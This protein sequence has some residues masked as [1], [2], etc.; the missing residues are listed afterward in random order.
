MAR[1]RSIKPE[2]WTSD[3]VVECSTNAR[4]LFIG[5]WNF[6]DDS[7]R[8]PYSPRRLKMCIFPGD[9]H[10]TTDDVAHLMQ[11]LVASK[12]IVPYEVNGERY[13][14]VSGWSHQKI[15]KR[16]EPKWAGPE[17]GTILET[18]HDDS[19]NDRG[20]VADESGLI[21]K[22]TIG[23]D[24]KGNTPIAPKGA[25]K[26]TPQFEEFWKA[27]PQRVGKERAFKAWGKSIKRIGGDR[28]AAAS[29][30]IGAAIDFAQ[31]TVGRGDYCP[32]PSTW[33]NAGQYDDDR[34]AWNRQSAGIPAEPVKQQAL[35]S[36]EIRNW[37]P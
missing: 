31:S 2:F 3:Q 23:D 10:T 22:D 21:R 26:Y 18:V 24:T 12:L 5:M 28:N 16:Q 6:C 33:L 4:L 9:D 11:E 29:R 36:E 19:S 15:D 27:Y 32:H 13:F 20:T 35:T 25:K 1:I 30:I 14:V 17:E 7:G 34:A 8:H 37:K